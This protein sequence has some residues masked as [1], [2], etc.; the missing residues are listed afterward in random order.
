[1]VEP[2]LVPMSSNI[3]LSENL[4]TAKVVLPDPGNPII[5]TTG[6]KS[7]PFQLDSCITH[8]GQSS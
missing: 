8:Q 7:V 6:L 3:V 4:V 2:S 1:M 5:K